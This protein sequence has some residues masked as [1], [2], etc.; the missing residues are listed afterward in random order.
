M[1]VFFSPALVAVAWPAG[2]I[3]RSCG[4]VWIWERFGVGGFELGFG[5]LGCVR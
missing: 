4:V 2:E 1:G 5:G 3:V